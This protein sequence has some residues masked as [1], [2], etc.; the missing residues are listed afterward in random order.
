MRNNDRSLLLS[1]TRFGSPTYARDLAVAI[2]TIVTSNVDA[3]GIYHYS[4]EGAITWYDFAMFIKDHYGYN[5]KIRPIKTSEYKTAAVRPEVQCA[6][7]NEIQKNI[8]CGRSSLVTQ[9]E[10]MS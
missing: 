4:N 8:W 6:R 2:M 1:Q 7:Q 3:P 10:R 5:C 9:S